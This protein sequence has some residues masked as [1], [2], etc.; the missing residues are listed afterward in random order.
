MRQSFND[1]E[2]TKDDEAFVETE[3]EEQHTANDLK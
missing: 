3:M 1:S 2:A